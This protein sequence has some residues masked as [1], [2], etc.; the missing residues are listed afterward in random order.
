MTAAGS[1]PS[2][3]GRRR[4][5]GPSP[6]AGRV[7]ASR[8]ASRQ[9][10]PAAAARRVARVV[11]GSGSQDLNLQPSAPPGCGR[12]SAFAARQCTLPGPLHDPGHGASVGLPAEMEAGPSAD[13]FL[14]AGLASLGIEADEVELAVMAP[15][16]RCSGRRSSACSPSTSARSPG[17]RGRPLEGPRRMSALDLSLR[18]QAAAVAAGE[19]DA[20]ELLEAS[21]ARIEERNPAL[22]A[23]VATFP[24][25]S[26]EMI[27]AAPDGPSARRPD[28]D[29]GRVAAALARAALRRRRDADPRRARRVRPLP[30]PARRRRDDRRRR[31]HARGRRQQH[32][33]RLG[34]R[35]RPQP[36]EPRALPGRLLE[37]AGRGGRRR[38]RRR[39]QSAP[40]GSARSASRPPTAA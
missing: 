15:R 19:L 12:D 9:Q 7:A 8:A 3:R 35:P 32:R 31:Q 26:R 16:T 14:A 25:R 40:T 21:L 1:S 29:Q 2:G 4:A 17:A 33:Q 18:A 36:L 13:D 38:D 11:F 22:N 34:L 23:V 37:R 28:R 5:P 10:R 20:A 39:R 24:E 30:G 27:E 6:L